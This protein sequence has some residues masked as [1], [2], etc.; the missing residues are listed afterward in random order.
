MSIQ[1]AGKFSYTD[2]SL[3]LLACSP[4]TVYVLPKK[5]RGAI[6][7]VLYMSFIKSKTAPQS[8]AYVSDSARHLIGLYIYALEG[9][10][11][12]ISTMP[13]CVKLH[14]NTLLHTSGSL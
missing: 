7:H 5:A 6:A 12:L 8:K 1:A 3:M 2:L 14:G 13:G 4:S 11:S 9:S 10:N